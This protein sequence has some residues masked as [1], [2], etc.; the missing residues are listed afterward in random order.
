M[1]SADFAIAPCPV[2]LPVV[3]CVNA[4]TCMRLTLRLARGRLFSSSW[5]PRD[6]ST[7]RAD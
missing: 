1:G 2:D 7:Q 6:V 5:D 4:R 3:E